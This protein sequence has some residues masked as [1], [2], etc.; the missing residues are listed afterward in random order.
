VADDRHELLLDARQVLTRWAAPSSA[1]DALRGDYLTHLDNHADGLWREGPPEHLTASCIVLDETHENVLLCLHAKGG[2]WG[3]FGGHL[4]REDRTLVGAALRE[5]RE[6][7]GV[8]RLTLLSHDPVD[9]DRHAL[10]A[11]FGRCREH[12]DVTFAAT[13]DRAAPTA[14]SAESRDV[15]W[16]PL[17]AL[18]D[19]VVPDLPRRLERLRSALPR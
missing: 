19:G 6:E 3:Q 12:L 11:A 18:P 7:S 13:A 1:Q 4:E 9:L 16:W 8:E 17:D 2:F 10:S 15:A 14:V 5:T